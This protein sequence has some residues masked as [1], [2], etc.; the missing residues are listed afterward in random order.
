LHPI[1]VDGLLRLLV[2]N[3]PELDRE[4][5]AFL[6][7]EAGE[8]GRDR[9]PPRARALNERLGDLRSVDRLSE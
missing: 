2:E 6:L 3:L 1:L 7:L 9:L 4:W 8:R 5:K